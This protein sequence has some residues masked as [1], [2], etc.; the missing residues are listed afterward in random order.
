[1]G[2]LALGRENR[3]RRKAQGFTLDRLGE[4]AGLTSNYIGN[5]EAG[6]RD[7]SLSSVSSSACPR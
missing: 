5:I 2:M 6:Q 7:P 1:M 3:R 4:A